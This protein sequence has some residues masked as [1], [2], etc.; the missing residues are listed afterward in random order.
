MPVDPRARAAWPALGGIAYAVPGTIII[1]LGGE[2]LRIRD[3]GGADE[4]SAVPR[5]W[6]ISADPTASSRSTA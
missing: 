5:R 2:V 3:D 1:G 4:I 6:S